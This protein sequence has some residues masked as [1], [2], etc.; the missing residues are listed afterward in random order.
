MSLLFVLGFVCNDEPAEDMEL[1]RM[2][3]KEML[4]Q[5]VRLVQEELMEISPGVSCSHQQVCKG[6]FCTWLMRRCFRAGI[7]FNQ[8]PLKPWVRWHMSFQ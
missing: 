5:Q 1:S 3:S 8:V 2:E 6:V 7:D 4:K